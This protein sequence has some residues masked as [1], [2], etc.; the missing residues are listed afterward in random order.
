MSHADTTAFGVLQK[1]QY[2]NLFTYK[3]SGEAVKTP[4]WFALSDGKAY[5]MTVEGS[6]KV[7]R[8]RNNGRVL[9]GPADQRGNPLGATVGGQARLLGPDQVAPAKAALDK[10]Y[11]L[12]KA[13][14][15]FF[16]NIR[17]AQRAWIEIVPE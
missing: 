6:G 13:A 9:I 5:V 2:A 4:V 16:M 12:M 1:H 11:G 8:V 17:G 3:K 7:K 10:K 14:F 15:D